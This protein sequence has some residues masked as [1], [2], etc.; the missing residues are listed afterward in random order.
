M[1]IFEKQRAI[2]ITSCFIVTAAAKAAAATA[3]SRYTGWLN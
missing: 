2:I 3:V 1:K